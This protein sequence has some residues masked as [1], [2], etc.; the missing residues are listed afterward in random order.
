MKTILIDLDHTL[1]DTAAFKRHRMAILRR[2]G[3][4]RRQFE[5]AHRNIIRGMAVF[6][7]DAFLDY[8]FPD[9]KIRRKVLGEYQKLFGR[10]KGYNYPG[11]RAF[12]QKLARK[13]RLILLSYGHKQF[14]LRKFIQAGFGRFFK[15]VLI[16]GN[17]HKKEDLAA[18][19]KKYGP[20]L[21][22]LDDSPHV[23][24][25]ARA[26]GVKAVKIKKGKKNTAYYAALARRIERLSER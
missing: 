10:K 11:A 15:Y 23:I 6:H 18:F 17:L 2:F 1:I 21:I 12:V 24:A 5:E 26:L 7:P 20:H 13:H 14:Q 8:V 16:T 19:R 9:P 22:M 4:S 25:A 3:V